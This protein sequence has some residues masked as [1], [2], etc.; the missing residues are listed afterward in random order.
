MESDAQAIQGK[1]F[2]CVLGH[3][4]IVC[5]PNFPGAPCR[6]CNVD[7]GDLTAFDERQVAEWL[8]VKVSSVLRLLSNVGA[9]KTHSD[10]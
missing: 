1:V 6:A 10:A 3:M 5:R 7:T 9:G 4:W 8:D 2:Q